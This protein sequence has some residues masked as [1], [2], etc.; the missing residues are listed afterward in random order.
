MAIVLRGATPAPLLFRAFKRLLMLFALVSMMTACT[1]GQ[2]LSPAEVQAH[3]K[4][5]F[6]GSSSKVHRACVDALK[7]LGYQI[8]VERPEKGLI[9]TDRKLLG[10]QAFASGD[11]YAASATA[12][13]YSM[14]YTVEL[15]ASS[16]GEVS[17]VATPALFA[18]ADDMSS[19]PVW[20]LDGPNGMRANW[21]ELFDKIQS[22]L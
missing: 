19:K 4:A 12:V 13:Q 11:K 2:V 7:I 10:V 3:G 22:L 8:T 5:S 16:G 14:Q 6:R 21:K 15:A 17:V 18:N 1:S 20:K 9:V